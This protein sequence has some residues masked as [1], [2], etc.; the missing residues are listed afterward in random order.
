MTRT[1]DSLIIEAEQN[2]YSL[3]DL[4]AWSRAK[5]GIV[6]AADKRTRLRASDTYRQAMARASSISGLL[7]E[8]IE[9]QGRQP[10]MVAARDLVIAFLD[11]RQWPPCDIAAALDRNRQTVVEALR[12]IE[13]RRM[14]EARRLKVV[15]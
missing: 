4:I 12:R 6:T 1:L 2:G 5:N 9:A 13:Q 3:N 10:E 11:G 14:A 15:P 8:E 7:P